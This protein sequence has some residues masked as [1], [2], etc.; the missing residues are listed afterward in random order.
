MQ[1][2]RGHRNHKEKGKE[3]EV[4]GKTNHSF[5]T[6]K[7]HFSSRTYLRRS[8]KA[9]AASQEAAS[10]SLDELDFKSVQHIRTKLRITDRHTRSC[11]T[12][13]FIIDSYFV[14]IIALKIVQ[15]DMGS[16]S[17]HQRKLFLLYFNTTAL[18]KSHFALN[19][20]KQI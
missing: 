17:I 1:E 8:A 18:A 11:L 12:D 4:E 2:L 9:M 5:P 6:G 14:S 16:P 7:S 20:S 10:C 15:F 13:H 19:G 3:T